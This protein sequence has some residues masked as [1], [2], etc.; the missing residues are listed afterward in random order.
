MFI[1]VLFTIGKLWNQPRYPETNEWINKM[2]Y[3]YTMKYYASIKNKI[4]SFTGKQVELQI[5][6]LSEVSQAHKFLPHSKTIKLPIYRGI[7]H[8]FNS[9]STGETNGFKPLCYSTN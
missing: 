8:K 7:S 1:A 5:I 9:W 6:M 3:I 4:M 2:W